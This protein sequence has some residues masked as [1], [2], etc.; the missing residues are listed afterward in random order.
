MRTVPRRKPLEILDLRLHALETAVLLPQVMDENLAGGGEP[1][2]ARPALEQ[3]RAELLLQI[4][5][6]RFTADAVTLR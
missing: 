3:L 6:S 1:H 2:A 5:D 4:H